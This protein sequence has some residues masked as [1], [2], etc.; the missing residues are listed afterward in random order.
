MY[1]WAVNYSLSVGKQLVT[2]P[3]ANHATACGASP[4]K[5][6]GALNCGAQ[7]VLGF[8]ASE[9]QVVD[10]SCLADL[11]TLDFAGASDIAQVGMGWVVLV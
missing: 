9:G 2:I 4:V 7:I 8:F 10:T 5:T 11:R 6:P 3:Q 1:S